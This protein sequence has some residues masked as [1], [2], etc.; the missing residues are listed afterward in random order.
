MF[1]RES[2]WNANSDPKNAH[3]HKIKH[4]SNEH[5]ANL[6]HWLRN[7]NGI[8]SKERIEEVLKVLIEETKIR[9]LTA[10]FLGQHYPRD[11]SKPY[12]EYRDP[13]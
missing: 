8:Q 9:K 5:L 10:K 12:K 7:Y 6:I 11:N 3:K 1:T 13:K 4:L 2:V